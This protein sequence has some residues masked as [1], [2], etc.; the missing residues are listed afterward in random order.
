LARVAADGSNHAVTSRRLGNVVAT[1]VE[2]GLKVGVG[3]CSVEPVTRVRSSLRDLVGNRL[4]V[5][6]YNLQERVAL[7]RLGN[8]DAMLI[9]KSLELR[10]SPAGIC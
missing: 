1:L 2:P 3:P 4:V 5:L 9:G 6:T 8:W 10:V 7:T